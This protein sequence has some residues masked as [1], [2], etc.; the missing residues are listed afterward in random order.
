MI[1]IEDLH[2]EIRQCRACLSF[3]YSIEPPPLVWGKAPAPFMLIGQAPSRTDL[4]Q[5]HMYSGPAA[6]KLLSWL[7][8]AGF[9]DTDF[10][11]TIYMTALTKC[12]PGRLPGK[13]TDR[14]P[15]AKEQF[16]CGNWLESQINVVRPEVIILFGKLAID[17]FLGPGSMTDRIGRTYIQNG[18]EYI[19]LPHSS[20]ASTWLNLPENRGRLELALDQV[21]QARLKTI[22]DSFIS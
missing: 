22:A 16:L 2:Q 3:G 14:A 13:S 18:V 19:P 21:R 20:G 17:R 15:S 9:N 12:F 10:G 4:K 5:R 11:S 8:I 6:Q 7:R 1:E